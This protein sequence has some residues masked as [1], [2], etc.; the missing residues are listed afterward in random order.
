MGEV[1]RTRSR[2]L[3]VV[4]QDEA[5]G[6]RQPDLGFPHSSLPRI[7]SARARGASPLVTLGSS[8]RPAPGL[9]PHAQRLTCLPI[10]QPCQGL[11][12]VATGGRDS[13]ADPDAESH[14]N[15]AA[16]TWQDRRVDMP[17]SVVGLFA[18]VGGIE[19]GLHAAGGHTVLLCESWGPAESVLRHRFKSAELIG[20]VTRELADLPD[21][22]VLAAGFPCT[23]L[24][25][26]GRTAGITG[27]ASGLVITV[28]DLIERNGPDWVIL[29][30]VPNML[31]LARGAAI[32]SITSRLEELGYT[33][34]YRVVDSRAFGV[35]QRRRRV[36]LLASRS[37]DPVSALLGEDAG[38]PPSRRWRKD[39]YGFYW[40]EGNR[41]VGWAQDA[42]PTLKGST[43]ASIPSP[44]GIWLPSNPVG[45]RIVRPTIQSAEVL[46]GLPPNWTAAAPS[47]DR[48][49]LVGNAVTT[50]VA[51]WLGTRIAEPHDDVS[52]S[53]DSRPMLEHE[54]W[55]NA[56][57]GRE[58]KRWRA[59]VSEWPVRRR[60]RHLATVLET[61]GYEPL[62]LRATKGFRTRLEK[63]SLRF[64]PQ[65]Y[66]DLTLHEHAIG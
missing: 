42:V 21:C 16:S 33:W 59:V 25:Q 31:H 50:P 46:Q 30:N 23:D 32:S 10:Q 52:D 29:E 2:E 58:G 6:C 44:P 37:G 12:L 13:V 60:Y 3:G 57:Y 35:P 19:R 9:G 55:P 54:R 62:S 18:G 61:H 22:D 1:T 14:P 20:D 63:S 65:F 41:G 11:R 17:F 51:K 27:S 48:W 24:S 39:A 34:A 28:L 38:A 15:M 64:D 53:L 49:K 36:F 45:R 56:A 47:R 5:P 8:H 40:T 7:S 26:A 43:T 66:S 4:L